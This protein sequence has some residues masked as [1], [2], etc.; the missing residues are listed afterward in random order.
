MK[1]LTL[2]S[3]FAM[4]TVSGLSASGQE[5]VNF[6]D[7]VKPIFRDKC[8][9]CHNTNKKS[10]D[11]DLS[12]YSS[13]M[14]GGASGAVIEP[15]NSGNSYLYMLMS[16]Q[17]EPYMPPN[18]DRVPDEMLATV[19]KWIDGGAPETA[20]SKVMLPKK[21]GAD[22]SVSVTA[23]VRPEGPPPLP[24]V[25]NLEPVVKTTAT[26]AVSAIATSPW[27]KLIA[28]AGQK[29]V[30]L[31]HSETM[32]PLGVLP[33][34]EGQ[35]RVLKFSRNGSL[36]LA[37]GGHGAS[38]GL[39]VV[40][41]VKSGERVMEV[42][43]E[44][45]EVLAADIS[46]DQQLVAVGGPGKIV[47]VYNTN[48]KELV[49]E[50]RKHTDWIYSL[51]FSP[52]SVLLATS[53]R[54]GGV[55]VW[56]SHTGREY[57]TLPGHTA[58]VNSVSWRSDGNV[59]ATG[60]QDTTIKLWEM[61][62]GGQ[63]KSWGAHGGGVFSVEFCRDGRIV[64]SGRDRVTKL[65]DQNGAAVRDFE[66]F[67]DLALQATHCDET[68]RVI[69]GDWT[70][71]I[72][73]W[74]AADG[75]RLGTLSTNPP[76]LEER[77]AMAEALV[78]PA[79]QKL[80]E[81]QQLHQTAAAAV[82]AQQAKV[83]VATKVMA[84]TAKKAAD[85]AAVVAAYEPKIVA[86][87]QKEKSLVESSAALE[88]AI[89]EIRAAAEKAT[90][91]SG[92]TPA[93]EELRKLAETLTAQV[94]AR[95]TS[96]QE[97]TKSLEVTK[98]AIVALNAELETHKQTLQVDEQAAVAAKTA[99]DTESAAIVPLQQAAAMT[100]ANVATA[101]AEANRVNGL[102]SRWRNY[103]ALRD[104]LASLNAA[105]AARDQIQ[106]KSLETE[107]VVTEKTQ[108][109]VTAE[110]T[111]QTAATTMTAADQMMKALSE[112]AAELEQQKL[113]QEQ[114]LAK[115]EMALPMI[116]SAFAQAQAAV[117]L[118]PGDVEIKTS[119]DALAAVADKQEKGIAAIKEQVVV[120]A[121][122]M[123]KAKA[124]METAAQTITAAQQQI[125]QAE[126]MAANL[127]TEVTPLQEELKA[128]QSELAAA[129]QIVQQAQQVVESR[130]E[131]IRPQLQ[132][133]SVK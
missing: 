40:W 32:E 80:T 88:K 5:K 95:T 71:E 102:V 20:T 70:G 7:H 60:S 41:N 132:L 76:L 38:K 81:V 130:K 48:T 79:Q 103:V 87:L 46:A 106:L 66:A 34:P 108:Q 14:Q 15:G 35:A 101:T 83:D 3:M 126:Q 8:L 44:L 129:E 21:P 99:A 73:V 61:E 30:I 33:F 12:S 107:A 121:D 122:G 128:R 56:E 36:L 45:D 111:V 57:L 75:T 96:L 84:D 110:Q 93:D 26:T 25:L 67:N 133:S 58:A 28:V 100:E 59:L 119:A 31:Y 1:R 52:D 127:K 50:V 85:Q 89:P 10:S 125:E 113:V 82:A 112:K 16:H 78:A 94:A 114:T 51:E 55:H 54:N 117:N 120:L 77:V 90:A 17:S 92:T 37:G 18:S 63:I 27:A 23:G 68:D 72:R 47:R 131:Q 24:D 6:E 109:I 91:A 43:D 118:L 69:A 22:L 98:A 104:E 116:K 53:D 115:I 19:Q 42:G 123:Q 11:L 64:S 4:L 105:V 74:N 29:Q 13:M 49:Y 65:W 62:N 86:E 2:L 97:M 124:E 39:A 9:S